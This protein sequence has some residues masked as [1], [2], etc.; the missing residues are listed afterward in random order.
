MEKKISKETRTYASE[1][2][3]KIFPILEGV[4]IAELKEIEQSIHNYIEH[5]SIIS[6]EELN[7]PNQ[8]KTP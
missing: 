1:I 4:S 5:Y 7:P 6:F 2:V 8:K 3:E